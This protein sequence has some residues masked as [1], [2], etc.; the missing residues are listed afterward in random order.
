MHNETQFASRLF[1]NEYP[2]LS[3]HNVSTSTYHPQTSGQPERYSPTLPAFLRNHVSENQN[4]WYFYLS[5][6]TY[7]YNNHVHPSAKTTPFDLVLRSLFPPLSLHH[8]VTARP[9][10]DWETK[11]D[12]LCRVDGGLQ[13][14]N[15]NQ[16]RTQERYKRDPDNCVREASRSVHASDYVYLD[17]TDRSPKLQPKTPNIALNSKLQTTAIEPFRVLSNEVSF[18][19]WTE[20]ALLNG[21]PQT[22]WHRVHPLLS[23]Y[24]LRSH[25]QTS[26]QT[27]APARCTQS[28]NY[29]TTG[30]AMTIAR[31]FSSSATRTVL[32]SESRAPTYGK[33]SCLRTSH[34]LAVV[35][36]VTSPFP[37]GLGGP[38]KQV[39]TAKI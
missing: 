36:V 31:T 24:R 32:I 12:F 26:P 11:K 38:P 30:S 8:S 17:F 27:L 13:T 19:S 28:I 6:L 35:P 7:A 34:E 37:L 23:P 10:L 20:T 1:Q 22:V 18:C 25:W 14:G 16:I 15:G 33:N 39:G 9:P 29:S 2:L 21:F 3:L 4:D 5:A